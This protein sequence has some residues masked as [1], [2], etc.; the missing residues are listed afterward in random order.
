MEHRTGDLT[1]RERPVHAA[2]RWTDRRELAAATGT[3]EPQ[4][5][6]QDPLGHL[7]PYEASSGVVTLCEP[8]VASRVSEV[9]SPR[10]SPTSSERAAELNSVP[11]VPSGY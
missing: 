8:H 3:D 4:N 7:I 2:Q 9:Y 11:S 1:M 6:G 10:R 5:R